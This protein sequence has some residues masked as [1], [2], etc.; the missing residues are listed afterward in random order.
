MNFSIISYTGRISLQA[1]GNEIEEW[2][3]G[4]PFRRPALFIIIKDPFF[5]LFAP[6]GFLGSTEPRLFSISSTCT[7][8][9]L[10]DMLRNRLFPSC[11]FTYVMFIVSVQAN[12]GMKVNESRKTSVILVYSREKLAPSHISPH[13][14]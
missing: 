1:L 5:F 2:N 6:L 4:L 11:R 3:H 13:V 12:K 10:L 14:R 9:R 7:S 8:Y